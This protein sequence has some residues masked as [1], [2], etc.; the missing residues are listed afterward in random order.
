MHWSYSPITDEHLVQG[1]ILLPNERLQSALEQVHRWFANPKYLGFLVL[2]QSCD[3]VRRDGEGCKSRY[4]TIAAIRPLRQ[5]LIA[6]L[7]Q[8]CARIAERYFLASDRGRATELIHRIINQ[9]E[10]SLGLFYLHPDASVGIAEEAV[11]LLRVSIALRSREHYDS[12]VSARTGRLN[13]EFANK[14]GWLC[15]NLYSRVGITDWTESDDRKA[16]ATT[17]VRGLLDGPA[18]IAPR[19]VDSKKFEKDFRAGRVQLQTSTSAEVA[20]ALANYAG[21]AF[22]DVALDAIERV[23][24]A[25]GIDPSDISKIRQNISNDSAFSNSVRPGSE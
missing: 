14:L 15:G 1:D 2:T 10:A 25:H 18:E 17:L 9:N 23:M 6:L 4:V 19:F 16:Q 20:A 21:P 8:V 7:E 11:A 12:L 22:K 13:G 3:L 5:V 24:R